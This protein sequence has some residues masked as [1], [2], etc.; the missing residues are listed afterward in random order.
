MKQLLIVLFIL[1]L[2]CGSQENFGVELD[3]ILSK[4]DAKTFIKSNKA[5]SIFFH[6][7][8]NRTDLHNELK[9]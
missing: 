8:V 2:I 5:S 6:G 9:K 3:S 1:P 7:R 4:E